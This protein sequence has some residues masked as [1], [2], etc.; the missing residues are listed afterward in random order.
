MA[1]AR[2]TYGFGGPIVDANRNEA[3][4]DYITRGQCILS[5]SN[6]VDRAGLWNA[7]L[8]W[9]FSPWPFD[10]Y[11][12]MWNRM[13]FSGTVDTFVALDATP[14]YTLDSG[15]NWTNIVTVA[16]PVPVAP[17]VLF[18]PLIDPPG[19]AAPLNQVYYDSIIPLGGMTSFEWIGWRMRTGGLNER[20]SWTFCC[21][22]Y[23]DVEDPF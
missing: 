8:F 7:S 5:Q 17:P 13:R 21:F 1:K 11:T 23:E 2:V 16:G 20:A 6:K 19:V 22:L 3:T 18:N 14:S 4:T 9:H 10:P 15:A 12:S